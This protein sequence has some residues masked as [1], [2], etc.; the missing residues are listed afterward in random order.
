MSAFF[1][2][3]IV[4]HISFFFFNVGSFCIACDRIVNA[5]K[6]RSPFNRDVGCIYENVSSR[7]VTFAIYFS[8][9]FNPD[10][11][12]LGPAKLGSYRSKRLRMAQ[13]HSEWISGLC[14]D[15][16]MLATFIPVKQHESGKKENLYLI[17]C[18]S[19]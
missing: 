14:K 9:H 19:L 11:L 5:Q 16:G 17:I 10:S 4:V 13:I 2:H 7:S 6:F 15:L 12:G 1:K 8:P 18:L 3:E